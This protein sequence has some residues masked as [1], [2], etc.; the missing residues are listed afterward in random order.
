[1]VTCLASFA[2]SD[3]FVTA[4]VVVIGA[5]LLARVELQFPAMEEA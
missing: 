5:A 1:M 2:A 4:R 3:A